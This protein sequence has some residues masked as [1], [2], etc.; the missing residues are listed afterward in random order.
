MVVSMAPDRMIWAEMPTC[1]RRVTALGALRRRRLCDPA[2]PRSDR[3]IATDRSPRGC[4]ESK[5]WVSAEGAEHLLASS[6]GPI[7][8]VARSR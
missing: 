1:S 4:L 3:L 5:S 7:R 6:E 2:I 8:D